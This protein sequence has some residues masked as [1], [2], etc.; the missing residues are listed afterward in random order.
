MNEAN[1]VIIFKKGKVDDMA[2]FRPIAL[3]NTIYKFYAAII[4]NRLLDDRI[5]KTQYGFR[6]KKGTVQPIFAVKKRLQGFAEATGMPLIM[7][8]LDWEK[9][10]DKM[11]QN[12]LTKAVKRMNVPDEIIDALQTL[13]THPKARITDENGKSER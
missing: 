3:L 5:W 13:Y 1:V 12:E 2:N 4:G 6:A 7:V 10:C 8:F 9:A 11:N